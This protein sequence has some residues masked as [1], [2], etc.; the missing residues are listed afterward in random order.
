MIKKANLIYLSIIILFFITACD[1]PTDDNVIL[2]LDTRYTDELELTVDYIDKDFIADGIGLVEFERCVDGDTAGF[3]TGSQSIRVRFLGIDT[4][5][6]TGVIQPW[7][8]PA[9]S[10]TCEILTNA[11]EI[12]LESEEA[13]GLLDSSGS[14]Y[15]AWVWVD[16]R[17]LNLEILENGYSPTSGISGSKYANIFYDA[18]LKT[19]ATEKRI[20][21]EEDP[22]YDYSGNVYNVT[23][24]EIRTNYDDY[25]GKQ[26]RI[27]GLVTRK[28]GN[29]FYVESNGYGIYIYCAFK[30]TPHIEVGMDVDLIGSPAKYEDSIQLTGFNTTTALRENMI[31][32][33][34][35]NLIEASV[36]LISDI[37]SD[38]E[39][40]FVK[41][42]NLTVTSRYHNTN[43]YAYTIYAEDSF[44]NE[45]SIRHDNDV[46]PLIDYEQFQVGTTFDISGIISKFNGNYQIMLSL[47]E[48]IYIK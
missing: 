15:L 47:Q 37:N 39:G 26:V 11:D 9:S 13:M 35:N 5:E 41:I 29:H 14:R 2:E 34:S 3:Y 7:G 36:V 22:T 20:W 16:G 23:I 45:I 25:E 17:L 32:N 31:I 10:F 43:D 48:D 40:T 19:Q 6:S 8:R 44:G 21:G 33:S 42:E 30:A 18:D 1:D 27:N 28:I 4:P 12:V 24:Q 38:L 46:Y